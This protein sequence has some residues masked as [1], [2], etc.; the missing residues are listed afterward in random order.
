MPKKPELGGFISAP[1]FDKKSTSEG[2]ND[3]HMF[4][5]LLERTLKQP[6]PRTAISDSVLAPKPFNGTGAWL[7]YFE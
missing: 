6:A 5:E 7:E 2:A 4:A 1:G 3:P